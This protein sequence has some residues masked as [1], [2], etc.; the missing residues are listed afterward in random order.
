MYVHA[1][2]SWPA[3]VFNSNYNMGGSSEQPAGA[4][5]LIQ[6]TIACGTQVSKG[7][8]HDSR[9]LWIMTAINGNS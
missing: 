5:L 6:Y 3:Q 4:E 2:D 8:Y 7:A 9:L 1:V